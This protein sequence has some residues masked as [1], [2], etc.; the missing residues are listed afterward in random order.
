MALLGVA[1]HL[2]EVE[3]DISAGLPGLS[4]VGLPDTAVSESR[5]RVRAAILNSGESWP[6][7]RI[8]VSLS[9]AT[10]P[11][12]GSGFDL[13]IAVAVLAAAGG[14]PE[15]SL[16]STV[17]IGELALD[18]RVRPV[19]GV[20]PCA[21]TVTGEVRR[22]VVPEANGAEA[23]L[24]P[25][26]DVLPVASLRELLDV[27][28]GVRSARPAGGPPP[29]GG[30]DSAQ[31]TLDRADVLG[32]PAARVAA[33][34]AAAGGHHLFLVGAP[35]AGKT[36]LAERIPGLLPPLDR[37]A[38]LEVTAVHSVAGVLPPDRPLVTTPPFAAPHHTA[39]VPAIV[40]GGSGLSR[41]GAASLAHRG[42]LFLDEAPEFSPGALEA[43]REPLESGHILLSRAGGTVRYPARFALVL[44]AN[45]CPCGF[46]VGKGLACRCTAHARRRYL[47]R[48]SGPLLDRVDL[49][50][51]LH[52][53]S[54]AEMF[55]D[56][57]LVE[58]TAVVAARVHEARERAAS[59]LRGTPWRVNAEVPGHELRRRFGSMRDALLPLAEDVE[60][61]I[62][63]ARGVDRVL[64]V[65]WT[66]AD[67]AGRDRPGRGDVLAAARLRRA[68]GAVAA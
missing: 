19:R 38:A 20:L 56:A 15:P 34:V 26:L 44:A 16:D 60:R 18:G 45:P 59:R 36:M 29:R 37:A 11:K 27:L 12:R 23:A 22:V 30:Q 2:V 13:P 9:P 52:P 4:L 8:T 53:V 1:G 49:Q 21:L 40:G 3:A 39:T 57:A 43:L 33:E 7:R 51:E 42:V 24:V 10:L 28:R 35:G 25:D 48:L 14:V 61:G 58:S 62:L 17:I 64:R 67:L 6:N 41:P 66:L 32:Q 31:P 55:E 47:G 5:D 46:A 50:V 63:T 54:R 65:A 68:G